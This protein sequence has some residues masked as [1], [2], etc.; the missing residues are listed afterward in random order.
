MTD[1][2]GQQ[3]LQYRARQYAH[4]LGDERLADLLCDVADTIDRL[5]AE[6]E[7]ERRAAELLRAMNRQAVLS[8]STLLELSRW[9]EADAERARK[10]K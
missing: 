10:A 6:R 8:A 3:S 2:T 7:H 9:H 1:V 4:E 5:E